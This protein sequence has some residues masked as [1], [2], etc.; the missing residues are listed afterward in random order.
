MIKFVRSLLVCSTM[1]TVFSSCISLKP[2]ERQ[3][4]DDPEMQMGLDSGQNFN[5][6]ISS[7]REGATPAASSKGSGGCGC[8]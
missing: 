8:N 4:V 6:Y 3:F 2:Y 7:I 1:L 5:I